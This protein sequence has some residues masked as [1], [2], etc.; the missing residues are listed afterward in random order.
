MKEERTFHL[1]KN[2]PSAKLLRIFYILWF[3]F[4]IG[5]F[6][7]AGIYDIHYRYILFL[8]LSSIS[9]CEIYFICFKKISFGIEDWT[10]PKKYRPQLI[11]YYVHHNKLPKLGLIASGVL[12]IFA[13]AILFI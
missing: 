1:I 7:F 5:L 9:L 3:G 4:T 12:L 8:S 6:I 11:R 10:I 13:I 2:N